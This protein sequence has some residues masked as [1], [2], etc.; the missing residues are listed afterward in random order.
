MNRATHHR[1][2]S[3]SW[4]ATPVPRRVFK[5]HSENQSHKARTAVYRRAVKQGAAHYS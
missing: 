4:F 5:A 2:Y 3:P 1:L